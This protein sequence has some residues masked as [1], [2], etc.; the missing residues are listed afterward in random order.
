MRSRPD[1][2]ITLFHKALNSVGGGSYLSGSAEIGCTLNY[3]NEFYSGWSPL[4]EKECIHVS[5]THVEYLTHLMDI[6]KW[7]AEGMDIGGT[8][9]RLKDEYQANLSPYLNSLEEQQERH[10]E[11]QRLIDMGHQ[12]K[13]A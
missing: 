4:Q 8:I 5:L 12:T 3:R 9:Y 2:H 1:A 7:Q 13:A 11:C 10:R 6:E